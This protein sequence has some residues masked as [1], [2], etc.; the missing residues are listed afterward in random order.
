LLSVLLQESLGSGAISDTLRA[1][2]SQRAYNRAI[3]QSLMGRFFQWLWGKVGDALTAVAHT[4][5]RR[6]VFVGALA[7]LVATIIV[8]AITSRVGDA[9]GAE[10]PGTRRRGAASG[11]PWALAQQLAAAGDYTGAAHALYQGLLHAVARRDHIRL[12][13]SKT[14]GD[15]ARELRTRSSQR[16]G[17]FK[18]F[19]RTYEVVVYGLG[20]CD[21]DRYDRLQR[22]ALAI[23]NNHG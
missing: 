16:F 23:T 2:F 11:D 4:P 15:Y 13:E 18:E 8:H 20:T 9:A 21:R 19:A 7:L 12:H 1:V 17:P 5:S 22:L 14:V 6:W 3:P 10:R